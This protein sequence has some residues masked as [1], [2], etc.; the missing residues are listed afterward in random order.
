MP[1]RDE[2]L[3]R[4][5]DN[6]RRHDLRFPPP[7]TAP[8]TA[9]VRMTVTRAEGGPRELAERFG[10]ELETL[11]G[12]YEI[13]GSVVEARLT[14]ISRI[15]GWMAEEDANRRGP[16][17]NTGQERSILSW[18]PER[19]PVPGV[20][21]VF[22]D[23]GLTLVTPAALDSTEARDSVRFIRFGLTGVEAAAASTGS[24]FVLAGPEASRAASL[25]PLHHIALIPFSRLYPSIEDWLA[26]KRRDG[27][28]VNMLRDGA[29]LSMITGPS[30]SADIESH[31]T[32]GVHGP[33]FVHAILF[34]DQTEL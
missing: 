15:Q 33:K 30:K 34:D 1:A 2:I 24:I 5:R 6:L 7:K 31:L 22:E 17:P 20:Q 28:L 26:E 25:L 29:N 8:L 13:V 23:M 10:Q 11:H 27:Q 18:D 3:T 4:L 19:L 14:L 9:D 16:A 21:A 32:L 12:T